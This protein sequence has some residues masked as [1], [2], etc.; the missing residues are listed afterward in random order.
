M[1]SLI[2]SFDA[3]SDENN[4]FEMGD[5]I[6]SASK[7]VTKQVVDSDSEVDEI[8]D[9]NVDSGKFNDDINNKK[10]ASTSNTTS[11]SPMKNTPIVEKIG[12]LEK[13]ITDGKANFVDD[14]GKPVPVVDGKRKG[15]PFSKV[16][17]VVV[18]DSDDEVD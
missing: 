1:V 16:G 8:I 9:M 18:S 17:E 2:N 5:G 11:S 14:N 15:N 6:W 13:L 7:N 12:K 4:I 10:E 3:L